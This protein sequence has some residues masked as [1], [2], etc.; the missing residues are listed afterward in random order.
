MKLKKVLCFI[1]V[2]IVLFTLTEVKAFSVDNDTFYIQPGKKEEVHLYANVEEEVT[3]VTFDLT[4][5]SFDASATFTP[6]RGYKDKYDGFNNHVVTL[7][8]P[9]SGK[10][11]LGVITIKTK[12][13]AKVKD[14]AETVLI[15]KGVAK[16][17][18]DTEI[19]LDRINM[20]VYL[21]NKPD[22]EEET[23]PVIDTKSDGFLESIESSIVTIDLKK[24]VFEYTVTV[25]ANTE[26]LDLKPIT[27]S[28]TI[29]VTIS[30][31]TIANLKDGAIYITLEDGKTT[32]QYKINVKVKKAVKE[33]EIDETTEVPEY[34]YK[35]KYLVVIGLCVVII[36]GAYFIKLPKG[37]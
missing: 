17:G 13:T 29:K 6:A 9:T 2:F 23:E 20:L 36:A 21:G 24:N 11:D 22:P 27:K 12:A 28:E 35:W 15:N 32:Q 18:E 5:S 4:F 30:D 37:D 16:N 26:V 14:T 25:P 10:I 3:S 19:T 1:A 8:E 31:Q 33:T 7:D 34:H